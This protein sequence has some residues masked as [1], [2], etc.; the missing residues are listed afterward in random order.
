MPA[1]DKEIDGVREGVCAGTSLEDV[2]AYLA[3]FPEVHFYKGCFPES[4]GTFADSPARFCF[5]HLDVD[6]Y[7]ST[8]DGLEYFYPR[9]NRGG[10]ILS[11]DYCSIGLA[12]VKRGF[13]EF[14]KDKPEPVI[15]L[16]DSQAL[17]VK[18]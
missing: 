9:M 8:K 6:I 18:A 4:A 13:D 15:E 7:E 16:W 12:G 11:H 3:R 10:I 14:M 17:L 1:V 2:R 5:V